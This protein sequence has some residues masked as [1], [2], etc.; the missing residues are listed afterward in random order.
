MSQRKNKLIIDMTPSVVDGKYKVKDHL[1]EDDSLLKEAEL[2][3]SQLG[4]LM[5][6]LIEPDDL[7]FIRK[8]TKLF[9][10]KSIEIHK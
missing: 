4:E 1:I 5:K 2:L 3:P 6:K 10:A 8:A 7:N 9:E